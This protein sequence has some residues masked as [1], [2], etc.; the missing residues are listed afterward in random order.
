M[1]YRSLVPSSLVF[2]VG[3]AALAGLAACAHNRPAVR[4]AA[5]G[6]SGA[7]QAAS[8]VAS[9]GSVA[10]RAGDATRCDEIRV[11]FAF[12]SADIAADERDLLQRSADCLAA[13]PAARVVV[14]GNADERGTVEYNVALGQRRADAV[15]SYL[16]RLGVAGARVKTIS[17]GKANPL[18]NDHDEGCWAKNRRAAVKPQTP[19]R[20]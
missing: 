11:H 15:A 14:E 3:L 16:E 19:T 2:V 12:D 10:A 13:T 8:P 20:S 6:G 7:A 4:D 5:G 17:Y 1:L 9:T 18:C